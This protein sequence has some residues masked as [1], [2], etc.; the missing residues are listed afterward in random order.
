MTKQIGDFVPTQLS[1]DIRGR[2]RCRIGMLLLMTPCH[3]SGQQGVASLHCTMDVIDQF[4]AVDSAGTFKQ[5]AATADDSH[6]VC[7]LVA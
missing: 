5:V 6:D 1:G 3:I 4:F 7:Q 2:A